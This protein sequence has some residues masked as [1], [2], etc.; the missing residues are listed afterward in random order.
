VVETSVDNFDRA[1]DASS[2]GI[3]Q[4]GS[5]DWVAATVGGMVGG[6]VVE[7]VSIWGNLS[8]WQAARHRARLLG[9]AL[10]RLTRYI[11]PLADALVAI[12]R[13]LLGAVAG[14][15]LHTQLSTTISAI[16][17]GAAAPALLSQ[18]GSAR[19]VLAE[20]DKTSS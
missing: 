14:V 9:R 19:R 1:S 11:D 6:A 15:L 5:M 18:L 20:P 4:D 13:L 7:A 3:D 2:P 10:P 12:T 17:V 8:S 16:A